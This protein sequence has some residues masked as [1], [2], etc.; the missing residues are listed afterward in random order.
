MVKV[1]VKSGEHIV[2]SHPIVYVNIINRQTIL[3]NCMDLTRVNNLYALSQKNIKI[4]ITTKT[5]IGKN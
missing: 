2:F 1:R 3:L 5:S 4:N